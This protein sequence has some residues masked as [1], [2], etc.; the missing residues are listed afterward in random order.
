MRSPRNQD[1]EQFEMNDSAMIRNPSVRNKISFQ[2]QNNIERIR[3]MDYIED[4]DRKVVGN[5]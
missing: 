1:P 2:N 5:A 3:H 4:E